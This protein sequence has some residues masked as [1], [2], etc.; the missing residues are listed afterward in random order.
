MSSKFWCLGVFIL[1]LVF[2]VSGCKS[3]G[4]GRDP[5]LGKT[6]VDPPTTNARSVYVERQN[7]NE[8]GVVPGG[9]PATA[10]SQEIPASS[11]PAGIIQ[12]GAGSVQTVY[13]P[14]GL[15][16]ADESV[17]VPQNETPTENAHL[18]WISAE[19]PQNAGPRG[20]SLS[21]LGTHELTEE[22]LANYRYV[23]DFSVMP[24]RKVPVGRSNGAASAESFPAGNSTAQGASRDPYIPQPR[25]FVSQ[26]FDPYAPNRQF[27]RRK[28][29]L[30]RT[31]ASE[32]DEA[33]PNSSPYSV[34]AQT[35]NYNSPR[36]ET[37]YAPD[38][39]AQT[40]ISAKDS[41]W[42]VIA[43]PDP[44]SSP[45]TAPLSNEA[46]AESQIAPVQQSVGAKAQVPEKAPQKT[47]ATEKVPENVGEKVQQSPKMDD[48]AVDLFDLPRK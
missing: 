17:P 47:S 20:P 29:K 6:R 27:E 30:S 1:T 43:S 19:V 2:C 15:D 40:Q 24:P 9:S 14:N 48:S 11:D 42:R 23:Y 45:S 41:G 4:S 46:V 31:M 7:V 35:A 21:D 34:P 36:N 26:N 33:E 28:A 32:F 5:L 8:C 38:Q 16:S 25:Q 37:T 39:I 12:P 3:C 13:Y 44:V 10:V 22:E 18:H